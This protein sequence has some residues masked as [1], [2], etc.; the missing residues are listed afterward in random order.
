MEKIRLV[1][2]DDHPI[3]REG[4]VSILGSEPDLDVVG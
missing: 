1:I 3:F 4:V 2:I